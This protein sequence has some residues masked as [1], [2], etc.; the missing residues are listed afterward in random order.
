VATGITFTTQPVAE[1]GAVAHDLLR[2][3][4]RSHVVGGGA[5]GNVEI[6][7][8]ADRS[9]RRDLRID[10]TVD[11]AS[12]PS[13]RENY[14]KD[15]YQNPEKSSPTIAVTNPVPIFHVVPRVDKRVGSGIILEDVLD[16]VGI[17]SSHDH[18]TG[19]CDVIR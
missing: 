4:R 12:H 5:A 18:R 7:F 19:R 15:Q 9:R 6:D 1:N 16:S 3:Q 11:L 8:G 2:G 14:E 13:G 17:H 10:P